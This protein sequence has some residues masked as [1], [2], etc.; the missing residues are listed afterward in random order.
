MV[1]R[2][3]IL[4]VVAGLFLLGGCTSVVPTQQGQQQLPE[5]IQPDKDCAGAGG[6]RVTPCPVRLTKHTKQ[7][8]VITVKGRHVADSAIGTINSCFSGHNCY[9][10]ERLGSSR[11]QWLITSGTACGGADVEFDATNS[12][13][14]KVGF[15]FL[16]VSNKYCR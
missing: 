11:T 3:D 15:Y 7:G 12:H 10:A 13:G 2:V 5:A 14:G 9:N 8:V 1:R 6:V 4:C 16:R